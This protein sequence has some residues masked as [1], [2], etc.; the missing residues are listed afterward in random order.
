[1]TPAAAI[2]RVLNAVDG[3]TID[4]DR[5]EA[6]AALLEAGVRVCGIALRRMSPHER[7]AE[8]FKIEQTIR[9]EV[10]ARSAPPPRNSNGR[11]EN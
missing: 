10:A 11:A 3:I 8:L 9:A 2:G 7:E 5:D 4:A 6:M 1:M